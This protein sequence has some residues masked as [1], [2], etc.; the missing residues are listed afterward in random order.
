MPREATARKHIVSFALLALLALG[1]AGCGSGN[2]TG[3]QPASGD[4]SGQSLP[5]VTAP[6]ATIASVP[7]SGAGKGGEPTATT[8]ASQ[9]EA[10][11]SAWTRYSR[12]SADGA[13]LS[14]R[15]PPTWT[16]D[17][18]YCP[19]AKN[20]NQGL[21]SDLL[22]GCATTDF[23]SAQKAAS[24]ATGIDQAKSKTL[25]AG[26]KRAATQIDTPLDTGK[27]SSTYTMLIYDDIG[28]AITGFVTYIG[29]G[30]P[31]ADRQAIIAT[32]DSIAATV[33]VEK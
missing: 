33:T 12:T 13:S 27:A 30:T 32:L 20:T 18:T 19:E 8:P 29:P 11:P 6:T 31:E 25:S 4:T 14:Y 21:G 5:A 3:S 10:G 28:T 9:A 2:G 7:T 16:Q 1:L 15:Y 26:G 23:L 17:L 22:T 24:V